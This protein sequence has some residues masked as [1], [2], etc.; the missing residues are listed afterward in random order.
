[1]LAQN[2]SKIK[3]ALGTRNT[4]DGNFLDF[5]EWLEIYEIFIIINYDILRAAWRD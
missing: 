4:E 2:V 1:M 5:T 3:T